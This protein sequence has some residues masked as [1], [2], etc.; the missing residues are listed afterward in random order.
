[1]A[2]ELPAQGSERRYDV[3]HAGRIDPVR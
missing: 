2:A 1:M 3:P